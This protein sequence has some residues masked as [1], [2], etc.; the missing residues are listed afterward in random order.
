MAATANP[1]A[2]DSKNARY[3]ASFIDHL[4]R[5]RGLSPHTATSYARDVRA[6]LGL[7]AAP[8][9]FV[10]RDHD[11]AD[12]AGSGD[13]QRDALAELKIHHIR[14]FV[15]R[16]H[17]RGLSGK[18]L[19]RMLSAWRCFFN[20][21]A[22]DHGFSHNP[23]VGL[24]APKSPR[25]LPQ[26]LSPDAAVQFLDARSSGNDAQTPLGLRDKA[27]FELGYSSGL[28]L[29]E[30]TG[31]DL[32]DLLGD[33]TVRV[34]GKGSKTRIVPVGAFARRA[35]DEWI[36]SRALLAGT[37][38]PALFINARGGRLS[39]RA[40]QY[41]I[42]QWAV[43][44]GAASNVHPHMLRHSFASHLLQSSGDLRAVQEMLGHASI[45]TTQIYA[46]L[47]FQY[48]AR[49]YDKAHPRAKRKG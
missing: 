4:S 23:C 10:G 14:S 22:R 38:E 39:G 26:A 45:S 33:G 7:L 5:E 24:R 48:L 21:L 49:V 8:A 12:P 28:R 40:I 17:A 15:G 3:L 16:L 9:A 1:T 18:S 13:Q 27:I 25:T 46:H 6:L 30:L 47:D 42:K 32:T 19:A 44:H 34:T 31:L 36:A 29:A 2:P 11:A 41:R 37:E 43:K 35:L 20:Y